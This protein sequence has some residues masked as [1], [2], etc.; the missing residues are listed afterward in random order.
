MPDT[1]YKLNQPG[2]IHLVLTF[3][4]LGER[5]DLLPYLLPDL[6]YLLYIILPCMFLSSISM[7]QLTKDQMFGRQ[8][9]LY[10]AYH[11]HYSLINMA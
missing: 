1:L 7:S 5:E 4:C 11:L 6:L 9:D 2:R 3:Y 10:S 8:L